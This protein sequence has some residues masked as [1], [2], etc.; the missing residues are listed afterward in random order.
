MGKK[1]FRE[2]VDDGRVIAPMNVDGM[3]WYRPGRR[4]PRSPADASGSSAA[5][6]PEKMTLG[7][8]MAFAAGVMKA[9]ML[10]ALIFVGA[11]LGFILFCIYVWFK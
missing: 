9:V 5:G 6:A 1:K 10:V 3:P 11:L 8:N 2:D 7:E 4:E